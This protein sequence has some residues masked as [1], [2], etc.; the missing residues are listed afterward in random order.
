MS[1]GETRHLSARHGWLATPGCSIFVADRGAVRFDYPSTW[2][3]GP[4]EGSVSLYDAEPPDDNSRLTV[5]YVRLPPADWRGLPLDGL[6]EAT[7]RDDEHPDAERGA[8][9]TRADG[10]LELA[11]REVRFTDVSGRAAC[12]LICLAREVPVQA[13]LTFDFWASD[14]DQ[15]LR[16]WQTVLRTLRLAEHIADPTRGPL[17]S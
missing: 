2:V 17:V 14:R 12:S 16:A 13:L 5:S 11:W 6:L 15:C 7:S 3:F 8:I 9:V 4:G 10:M 1:T